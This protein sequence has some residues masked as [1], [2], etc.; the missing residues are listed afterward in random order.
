MTRTMD[1]VRREVQKSYRR[2]QNWRRVGAELGITCGMAWRIGVQGYEPKEGRIRVRRGLSAMGVAPAC[3]RCGVVHVS[4]KCT[5]SQVLRWR[6]DL[7]D[8]PVGELRRAL[9]NRQDLHDLQDFKKD[10]QDV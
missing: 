6:R 2:L 1:S 10:G 7:W 3:T 4:K 5:R 9:E 8:W